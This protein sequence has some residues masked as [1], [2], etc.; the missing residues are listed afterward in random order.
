MPQQD[1]QIF[2]GAS[3]NPDDSINK[4]EYLTLKFGNRHGL[5]TG[6]TGTGKTVTLQ[7]LAEG[8]SKAG[9]PV[10]CADIKGDLSGIAA[11]GE[12]KD[13]LL[14]RAEEVGLKPYESEQFPVIFW[15][16][17]GEKGH[18]VRAT[19]A[20]MGPLLLS[21]LMDASEAQE[22]VL[23]IAFKIADENGLPLLDLKDFQSLLNYMGENASELSSKYGLISKTSVGSLQ[24]SLLVLEQQGAENFFGEP[25]LKISDIMRVNNNGYGQVSVLAADKLM[26]N[27]RLYATFLLWLLSE[28]FEELP[29]VGDPEKPRLVFFFDEAH[30][31]FNDAPRV[32]IERV[33]QV[34]RLIRSKGVGVYFVTQNPLDVPETVLAQL[35]NRVQHAL[36]A[37]SPREQKAVQTAASTFR[38]NPAFKTADIITT[39]GTGEALVSMLEA[40]G[41]PS[42]VERTLIRPPSGRIGPLTDAERQAIINAS[43]VAGLYDE[44]LDRESAYEILAARAGKAAD[45]AAAKEDGDSTGG[46]T[47]PGFGGDSNKPAGRGR[48]GYQRETILEATMKSVARTVAT[49]VGR[50]LVRGILG[51]LKR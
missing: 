40:K 43:P 49:Q 9:V 30:L 25:A 51:S 13:F 8:F 12:P 6:A 7:V 10:F 28:L 37:Y 26:M 35:G 2:V 4:S 27:P 44:T 29:E 15:D 23:N 38:P 45:Q 33:E 17:Y 16:I 32:L 39:L 48:S 19:I 24:R 1:G 46:W 31:L 20:E 47:L 42:I 21:R 34:V 11:K 22:G 5:I 41:A 36:R 50:A 14:K 18:R 3:R